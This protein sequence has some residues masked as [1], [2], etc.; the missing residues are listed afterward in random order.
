[1][2]WQEI[3][4]WVTHKLVSNVPCV[5]TQ[6]EQIS[7]LFPSCAVTCAMAKA[8]EKAVQ[9]T[10]ERSRQDECSNM[11]TDSEAVVQKTNRECELIEQ[12]RDGA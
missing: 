11:V 2:T 8:A 4:L 9:A 6:R 7:N 1:M 3:R 12:S 10:Q 5:A